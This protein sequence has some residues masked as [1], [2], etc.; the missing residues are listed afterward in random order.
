MDHEKEYARVKEL[1]DIIDDTKD[2]DI[3]KKSFKEL[4]LIKDSIQSISTIKSDE[5]PSFI[6]PYPSITDKTFYKNILRK[7]EFRDNKYD[8]IKHELSDKNCNNEN[9]V[10]TLNQTFL[11]NFMSPYTPYNSLLLFHGVGV[12]KTCTAITIAEQFID[13]KRP[14]YVLMPSQLLKTNF[15]KQ[16]FNSLKSEYD[17]CVASKYYD[18]IPNYKHLHSDLVEKKV[19]KIINNRYKFYGLLEFANEIRKIAKEMNVNEDEFESNI[20]FHKR[21]NLEYKNSIFI[22]DEVHNIRLNSDLTKKRV[23]P[24]LNILFKHVSNAKLLLMTATPMFNDP[25]EIIYILN[26]MLY[27]DKRSPVKFS[28]LFEKNGLLKSKSKF[29]NLL[30]GYVSYMR[31]NN[32]LTFPI[33]LYPSI[34]NDSKVLKQ[35]EIPMYDIKNKKIDPNDMIDVTNF[36]MIKSEFSEI[37]SRLYL[38]ADKYANLDIDDVE[39]NMSQSVQICIQLSNIVYP[40]S[41]N[42]EGCYGE[43][44][45]WECFTKLKSKT[46]SVK[47]K[48]KFKDM[49]NYN[50]V[51]N[52]SCKIKTI[53]DYVQNSTGIVFIYSNWK[54]SGVIP[55]AIALE[56]LGY[57]KYNQNNIL[58]SSKP[59]SK[60]NYII[61]SGDKELSPDNDGEIHVLK[62]SENANGNFIKVVLATSVATEGID[63]K[64]IREVH[65]LEPWFHMNK[66]EQI[67]GRAVRTCSHEML[68][69]HQRNVTIYQHVSYNSKAKSENID[70]RFYRIGFIKQKKIKLIEHYMKE[71]A[72]DCVLNENINNI[73]HYDLFNG[74]T[75]ETSQGK[76]VKYNIVP[77]DDN[78]KCIVSL[79]LETDTSTFDV[80]FYSSLI[81]QYERF[82]KLYFKDQLSATYQEIYEY[83]Q[84]KIKDMKEE[85]LNHALQSLVINK[86]Y[87]YNNELINGHLIYISNKYVFN[88]IGTSNFMS[89]NSRIERRVSKELMQVSIDQNNIKNQ[90]DIVNILEDTIKSFCERLNIPVDKVQKHERFIIDYHIDRLS[91]N[92][93][94]ELCKLIFTDTSDHISK[95]VLSLDRENMIIRKNDKPLFIVSPHDTMNELYTFDYKTLTIRQITELERKENRIIL[96]NQDKTKKE[97]LNNFDAYKAYLICTSEGKGSFKIIQKD[98]KSLGFICD[99]TASLKVNDFKTIIN[100]IDDSFLSKSNKRYD[101]KMLCSLYEL[102]L[103]TS[104]DFARPYTIN[105]VLDL[106]KK[107]K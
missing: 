87:F 13:F 94:F 1:I 86:T 26:L 19:N 7:K 82:I 107:M 106:M 20:K 103:R 100:S 70:L 40:V 29:K 80:K 30:Q 49:L 45:F 89:L 18:M 85:V 96:E 50:N 6:E 74:S 84:L 60:N 36:E 69:V 102:L 51:H 58:N 55:L 61:L 42:V 38:K 73:S 93:F 75:I 97:S 44:G 16:I 31:G 104:G 34:N 95:Y 66:I 77:S 37:Q 46:F 15:R 17:Q 3:L 78:N 32:P 33:R 92:D 53:L 39:S 105:L 101:K 24:I 57:S 48:N 56:H 5:Y 25:K 35:N 67:I 63:L 79:P 21:L 2:S 28:T 90:Y 72:I 8:K 71:M 4:Q 64:C 52:V 11:R 43:N 68:P 91:K 27:N 22:I 98:K 88:P 14:V 10:L 41:E 76:K 59:N 99:Q 47:Y 12:G 65:I 54:W 83:V 81:T 9:F 62:S 23:P